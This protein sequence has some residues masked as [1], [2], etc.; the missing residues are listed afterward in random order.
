ML[1][2]R[3]PDRRQALA[4]PLPLAFRSRAARI[5]QR[6]PSTGLFSRLEFLCLPGRVR[7]CLA[8]GLLHVALLQVMLKPTLVPARGGVVS[9]TLNPT[10]RPRARAVAATGRALRD[11]S[12]GHLLQQQLWDRQPGSLAFALVN[13]A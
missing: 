5:G 9:L 6:M 13:G 3:E 2:R 4:E 7:S 12:H 1:A 10:G 11:S 8:G